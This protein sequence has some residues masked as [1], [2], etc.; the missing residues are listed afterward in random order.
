MCVVSAM[1]FLSGSIRYLPDTTKLPCGM[2]CVLTSSVIIIF[3]LA[4]VVLSHSSRLL[5]NVHTSHHYQILRRHVT[6]EEG[7]G[8]KASCASRLMIEIWC[9]KLRMSTSACESALKSCGWSYSA[10]VLRSQSP[11]ESNAWMSRFLQSLWRIPR[12]LLK[13]SSR[14]IPSPAVLTRLS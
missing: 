4:G 2:K 12:Y 3:G 6:Y 14:P 8:V 7:A 1:P 10:T 9:R 11:Y 5:W 13:N